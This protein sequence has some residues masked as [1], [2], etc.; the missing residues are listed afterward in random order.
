[1][2]E[3]RLLVSASNKNFD[4]ICITESW[5]NANISDYAVSVSNFTLHRDDRVNRIGGGVC[6]F[7]KNNL[8]HHRFFPTANKPCAMECVFLIICCSSNVRQQH[9]G[10]ISGSIYILHSNKRYYYFV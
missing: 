10:S 6:V 3:L 9:M 2:N 1:M 8:D 5:L 7:I 4:C